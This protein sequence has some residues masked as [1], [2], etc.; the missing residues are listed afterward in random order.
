M[1]LIVTTFKKRAPC[2][3]NATNLLGRAV[4]GHGWLLL[5]RGFGT[6]CRWWFQLKVI[7]RQRAFR[8][9]LALKV[10]LAVLIYCIDTVEQTCVFLR[11][12]M[13]AAMRIQTS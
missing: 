1:H 12:I 5:G 3:R 9:P 2:S 10:V 13:K 11:F 7:L 8:K 6:N 4:W